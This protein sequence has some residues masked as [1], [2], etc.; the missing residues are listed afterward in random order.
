MA[1]TEEKSQLVEQVEEVQ[2]KEE[3]KSFDANAFTE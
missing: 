3:V 2:E 1:K